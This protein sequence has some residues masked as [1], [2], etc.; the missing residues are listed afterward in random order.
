MSFEIKEN[1]EENEKIVRTPMISA[2][3]NTYTDGQLQ[4]EDTTDDVVVITEQPKPDK[5][6]KFKNV[7]KT[8]KVLISSRH[9]KITTSINTTCNC[10]RR[11]GAAFKNACCLDWNRCCFHF[12]FFLLRAP[13]CLPNFGYLVCIDCWT[14]FNDTMKEDELD[15]E[16]QKS[17]NERVQT[18]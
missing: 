7:N 14:R 9:T 6:S 5:K 4:L 3:N 16:A 1:N 12:S 11:L 15:E 8:E 17:K 2:N 18:I 10:C 13:C